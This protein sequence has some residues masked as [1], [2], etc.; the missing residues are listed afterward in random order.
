MRFICSRKCLIF[1]RTII[2]RMRRE[3][4]RVSWFLAS[5]ESDFGWLILVNSNPGAFLHKWTSGSPRGAGRPLNWRMFIVPA[6]GTLLMNNALPSPYLHNSLL[7]DTQREGITMMHGE[8]TIPTN[9]RPCKPIETVRTV[10][11]NQWHWFTMPTA[12]VNDVLRWL[13]AIQAQPISGE[14][15]NYFF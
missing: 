4:K 15:F 13:P 1:T 12:V 14:I 9:V 7:L 6:T 10:R 2:L 5:G 3:W 8:E 11:R